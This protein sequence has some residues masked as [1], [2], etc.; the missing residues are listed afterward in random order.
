MKQQTKALNKSHYNSYVPIKKNGL[1][2]AKNKQQHR[3]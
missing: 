2:H 3:I 1:K